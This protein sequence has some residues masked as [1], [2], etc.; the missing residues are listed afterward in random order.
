M[1]HLRREDH[2]LLAGVV[3][4]NARLERRAERVGVTNRLQQ[5]RRVETVLRRLTPRGARELFGQRLAGSDGTIDARSPM[6]PHPSR[7]LVVNGSNVVE[8]HDRL[9]LRPVARRVDPLE[10][11][12]ELRRPLARR[13][14]LDEIS[15][16]GGK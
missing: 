12:G 3:E 7:Q 16:R 15:H 10:Q 13:I 4:E 9:R 8:Q 14:M 11:F 5:P 6:Q 1:P 2:R